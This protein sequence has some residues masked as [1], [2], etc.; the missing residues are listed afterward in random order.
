VSEDIRA[1]A[2]DYFEYLSETEPTEAHMRG[3]YRYVDRFEE[4]SREAEDADVGRRWDFAARARLV[5]PANL[6]TSD[7]ISRDTLIFDAETTAALGEMHLDEFKVD[8]T[9]GMQAML[10]VIVRQLSVETPEHAE[11]M[12]DKYVAIGRA[13]DQ[14]TER[15]REGVARGRTPARFAVEKTVAQLGDQLE[16]SIDADPLLDLRT[17]PAFDERAVTAWKDRLAATIHEQIRPAMAR[18]REVIQH[19]V[20]PAARPDAKAGV[21][22]L[23]DGGV[24]Y[25]RA[26]RRWTTLP[27]QAQEIHEIGLHQIDRLADEYREIGADLLGTTDLAAIFSRLRSDPD[28]HHLTSEGVIAASEAAFGKAKALMGEWFGKLPEAD[29]VVQGTK[30]GPIAFYFPPADDG[31]R[32]GTF[33]MNTDDPTSWGRHEVEATSYHEGIPGHHLQVGIA[34]ELGDSVPAFRRHGYIGAYAEGWALYTERLADEMGLYESQLAR[35]GMLSLDSLRASRLVVD[36]G[37]HALGWS[38][39]RAIDYVA[40]NSPMSL[41]AIEGE[42]DRYIGF[43]GQALSYMIGRLEIQRIRA[44]AETALG[45]RFDIRRFHDVVL[46]SGGMTLETLDRTVAEWLVAEQGDGGEGGI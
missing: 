40:D 5:D 44:D 20:G 43:P 4:L 31:S 14:A 18:Q 42:V 15:L 28:L 16:V 1:I 23:A 25:E 2:A 30:A 37:I 6:D 13:Y 12:L 22:W 32:P 3:D 45:T 19:E 36:T 24:L 33:F 46:G 7:R 9:M 8:P 26:I 39:R 34:I 41:H 17:P 35:M 29:C 10:P 21:T 27:M 38:R 11:A